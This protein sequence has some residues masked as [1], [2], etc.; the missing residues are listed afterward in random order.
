MERKIIPYKPE[1]K[2]LAR[3]LRNCSTK[4]EIK[5]WVQLKG[6]QM[7]GYD[8]HRQKPLL[9]YIAD[10]YCPELN[11]VIEIDGYSHEFEET[12]IRDKRKEIELKKW[13]ITVLRFRDEDVHGDLENVLRGIELYIVDFVKHTPNPSQEG[14]F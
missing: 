12:Q 6:K 10:F 7:L 14:N 1:L 9:N 3:E 11:L 4:A 8:F 5:L 2:D 13:G